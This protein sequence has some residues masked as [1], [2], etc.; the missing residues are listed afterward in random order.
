MKSSK[1]IGVILLVAGIAL[2][3]Y[4]LNL[5]NS[6][7]SQLAGFLGSE[8]NGPELYIILGAIASI[9]GIVLLVR[10]R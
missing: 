10:K 1:I 5:Q 6:F 2:A 4:G 7:E 3:A 8:D 9:V